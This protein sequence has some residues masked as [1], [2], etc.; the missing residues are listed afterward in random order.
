MEPRAGRGRSISMEGRGVV[1]AVGF[2]TAVG[3]RNLDKKKKTTRGTVGATIKRNIYCMS[4]HRVVAVTAPKDVVGQETGGKVGRTN[5]HP[6]SK[7]GVHH[8][9]PR[10]IDRSIPTDACGRRAHT[11]THPSPPKWWHGIIRANADIRCQK[12]TVA[13]GCQQ[14]VALSTRTCPNARL[15]RPQLCP[16][17]S[18]ADSGSSPTAAS[19]AFC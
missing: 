1:I 14:A 6:I 17:A 5:Q 3:Y 12:Q 4:V 10:P 19:A 13:G 9:F 8:R 7:N 2:A 18:A 15:G 16:R 11:P